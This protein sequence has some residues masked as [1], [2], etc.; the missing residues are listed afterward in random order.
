MEKA[1]YAIMRFAKYKGL[2]IGNIEAHN[3][4][5]KENYA[6]NPDVDSSRSKYN[7]HLVK[8]PGKVS[9]GRN[10]SGKLPLPD[11]V[12]GKTVSV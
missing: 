7:F 9:T 2:E 1:Q 10:Q 11:V 6:S 3:E 8:P 4:R 12:P 5:T